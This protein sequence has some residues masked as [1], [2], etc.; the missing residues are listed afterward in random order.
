MRQGLSPPPHL[1][2]WSWSPAPIPGPRRR[3]LVAG[4]CTALLPVLTLSSPHP[5]TPAPLPF[6]HKSNSQGGFH[7]FLK[8]IP[9]VSMIYT[10]PE[11]N[12]GNE[13]AQHP[14]SPSTTLP[15]RCHHR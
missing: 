7:G 8:I 13:A 15:S 14:P 11:P 10:V 5:N 9:L 1:S 12:H 2:P 4:P 3:A 6:K